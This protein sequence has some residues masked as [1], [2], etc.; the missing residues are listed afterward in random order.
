[1]EIAR[2]KQARER[3]KEKVC[4]FERERERESECGR[5]KEACKIILILVDKSEI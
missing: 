5:V 2:G 3:M 4:D 1:M